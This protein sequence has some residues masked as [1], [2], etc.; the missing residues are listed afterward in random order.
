MSTFPVAIVQMSVVG[1]DPDHNL[2]VAKQRIAQAA[3]RG[4]ALILLPEALDLGWTDPSSR[5]F[6]TTIPD[7]SSC[8]R[9]R[10]AA[11]QHGVHLC[12]GITERSGDAVYNAAVLISPEGEVLLHHRKLNELEIGHPYYDQGDRLGVAE[13]SLGRIGLMIC[14][15]AFADG[16]IVGRTLGLMGADLILS[17]CAWAV[18]STFNHKVTPYGQLWLDSYRPV[19]R[20]FE[21][22]VCAASNVGPIT[23]GPWAGRHCIGH[24]LAMDHAGNVIAQGPF[25]VDAEA[26]L[27][28]EITTSPRPTR[29][30]GWW[31]S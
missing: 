26:I 17:P 25:G 27:I 11:M 24:S 14:A 20:E 30:D 18:P 19:T 3:E 13:T 23:G 10:N 21:L 9:L 2:Q 7:G 5:S 8:R 1:G 22:S 15:D 31:T 4:A 6:A 12:G 29:G 16:L 28:V